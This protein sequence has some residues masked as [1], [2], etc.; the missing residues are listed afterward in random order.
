MN[1]QQWAEHTTLGA[2]CA[3]SEDPGVG[4][5]GDRLTPVHQEVKDRVSERDV[6]AQKV[7]LPYQLLRD[8]LHAELKLVNRILT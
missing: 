5:S 1:E 4:S 2:A 8:V 3:Q 6:H 7:Q